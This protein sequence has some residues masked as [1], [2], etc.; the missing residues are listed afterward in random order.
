VIC[1]HYSL[2]KAH[3]LKHGKKSAAKRLPSKW[4]AQPT[5]GKGPGRDVIENSQIIP[6]VVLFLDVVRIRFSIIWI[7]STQASELL[8]G[9]TDSIRFDRFSYR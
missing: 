2:P 1:Y 9:F 8:T 6:V 4:A 3:H 7:L 5:P